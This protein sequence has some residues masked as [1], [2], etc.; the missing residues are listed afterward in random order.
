MLVKSGGS[1]SCWAGVSERYINRDTMADKTGS[2]V[3]PYSIKSLV[4][5]TNF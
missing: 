3:I 4:A 1:S 2:E 5:N